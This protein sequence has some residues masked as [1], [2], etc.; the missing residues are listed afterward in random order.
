MDGFWEFAA[1]YW[2]LVFPLLGVLGGATEGFERWDKRRRKHK[3][4][5][6]RIKYGAGA[7]P[8]PGAGT[9][10]P[11]V[12]GRAH[13]ADVDRVV[14]EHDAVHRR[15][16]AYELDVDK[17]IDFPMMSDMREPLVV[18]FHRAKRHADGL[19][20]A[21]ADDVEDLVRLDAYRSSV[22]ELALAFEVAGREARRR[23]ASTFT[24][25]E[26]QALTKAKQLIA[27]AE[28][29]G[30]SA[31]ERHTAYRLAMRELEGLVAVPE[32]ATTALEQRI[33]GEIEQGSH[34]PATERDPA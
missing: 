15:W 6:A 20:P 17:L 28:D 24:A 34:P 12:R 10:A 3:L 25:S 22:E 27:I 13:R 31:S 4:E 9:T 33:A 5:L 18:D 2:W 19:R 16:L 21:R 14:A 26:R 23:R 7:G 11:T 30:A 29:R 1:S 8:V 32:G